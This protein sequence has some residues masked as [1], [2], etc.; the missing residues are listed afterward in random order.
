MTK[1]VSKNEQKRINKALN[2]SKNISKKYK[3]KIKNQNANEILGDIWIMLQKKQS[4]K[5]ITQNIIAISEKEYQEIPT[6]ISYQDLSNDPHPNSGLKEKIKKH[7]FEMEPKNQIAMI[8]YHGLLG[9]D[10]HTFDQIAKKTGLTIGVVKKRVYREMYV[11]KSTSS[12]H[13]L[14]HYI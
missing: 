14:Y 3:N 7:L 2:L 9:N 12:I 6:G 1:K 11:L 13:K 5:I 4:E 10:E 8:L